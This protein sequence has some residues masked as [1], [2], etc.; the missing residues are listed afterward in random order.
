M[1]TTTN[2]S[3]NL[4]PDGTGGVNINTTNVGGSSN[5]ALS[6]LNTDSGALGV[7]VNIK[8]ISATP[9]AA[10][11]LSNISISGKNDGGGDAIYSA[12]QTSIADP[13]AAYSTGNV[14]Y[15]VRKRDVSGTTSSVGTGIQLLGYQ[16]NTRGAVITNPAAGSVN[17]NLDTILRGNSTG[18]PA[19]WVDSS[20]NYVG[21]GKLTSSPPSTEL[22]I[23]GRTTTV[24][25]TVASN[26]LSGISGVEIDFNKTYES[27]DGI[28]SIAI[29]APHFAN[30]TTTLINTVPISPYQPVSINHPMYCCTTFNNY[31]YIGGNTA[32]YQID[33]SGNT[34]VNTYT[35]GGG[36]AT[37]YCLAEFNGFLYVGG[38]FIEAIGPSGGPTTTIYPHNV[39][40]IN[41]SNV[42]SLVQDATYIAEGFNDTC[43]CMTT[44]TDETTGSPTFGQS[45]IYFGGSFTSYG[46]V[47]LVGIPTP[48]R[49]TGITAGNEWLNSFCSNFAVTVASVFAISQGNSTIYSGSVIAVG[50]DFTQVYT[51]ANG[52]Q[53]FN[54][55][56]QFNLANLNV[57]SSGIAYPN[58]ISNNIYSITNYLGNLYVGGSFT[59]VNTDTSSPA[60]YTLIWD[61]ATNTTAGYAG[62]YSNTCYTFNPTSGVSNGGIGR[63]NLNN[64]SP[65][66]A[67]TNTYFGGSIDCRGLV[68][69]NNTWY[70]VSSTNLGGNPYV[71]VYTNEVTFTSV[72]DIYYN[73]AIVHSLSL[74]LPGETIVLVASTDQTKWYVICCNGGT[75][76]TGP[77]GPTGPTGSNGSQGDTGPTGPSGGPTGDTGP[78]GSGGPQGD[79]GPTGPTGS[80]DTG[81]TGP[82]GPTGDTGPPGGGGPQGDTGPTGPSGG[83]T[84]DT[85]PTGPTGNSGPIGDTGPTGPT[86]DIGPTGPS[87]G[88]TGD[89]GPTGPGDTG[90]TG[91]TG[92]TG[93]T[94]PSGGPPGPTGPQGD[95]GA[96]GP[97]GDTGPTGPSGGPTG[98]TGPTGPQG[99]TGPMGNSGSQGDTG[100]TGPPGGPTGPQGDTGA[101]G[102]QGDTGPTGPT[103]SGDTGPTGPQGDTGPSG[104]PTG[105]TGDTGPQG[106]TGPTGPIGTPA[107]GDV[108]A[109]GNNAGSYSI[110]MNTHDINNCNNITVS[111]PYNFSIISIF[112]TDTTR[113]LII[114]SPYTGQFCFIT[115]SNKLQFWNGGWTN[116]N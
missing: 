6:L 95:T 79:T 81:P 60:S 49:I 93:P 39:F 56:A 21:I 89:T 80:G 30:Q 103:G 73:G 104:G 70:I 114:P 94:G 11:I 68:L 41:T 8:K 15:Q 26:P 90:P 45:C 25:L 85:G 84:G 92:D 74:T 115:S 59:G 96:S 13:T 53:S 57:Y 91:P 36:S 112:D 113:D 34:I 40:R 106:D 19:V 99:D 50:G 17:G 37:V 83:P 67:L 44:G 12:M 61:I 64:I 24:G 42:M 52:Y 51:L 20:S 71:W 29:D 76:G 63:V 110:D 27:S 97:Q 54:Y 116:I 69:V 10:D 86:G 2:G 105:P 58:T 107:L 108:L 98:D 72:T 109:V 35:I 32:L 43:Y 78:T 47:V 4:N 16:S 3:I 65:P 18:R 7:Y 33:P 62:G 82:V 28:N 66:V 14:Q 101:S 9:A 46:A 75:S 38:N 55:L 5:P 22:E 23:D 111:S 102:P 100:P 87:G 77:T 88:P 48:N 1:T 31:V